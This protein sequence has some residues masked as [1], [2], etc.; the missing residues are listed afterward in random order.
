M[1]HLSR[2]LAALALLLTLTACGTAPQPGSTGP[3]AAELSLPFDAYRLSHA[4]ESRIEQ[5]R[6]LLVERCMRS[7]D[8]DLTLPAGISASGPLSLSPNARRYGVIDDDTA[9]RYGYHFPK[10][11]DEAAEVRK[12][13]TWESK[14]TDRH[15]TALYGEDGKPGCTDQAVTDI[16]KGVPESDGDFLSTRDFASL[17]ESAKN[18]DVVRAKAAWRECMTSAGFPYADPDAA[19]SDPRWKLDS[20][21]V[22]G[23]EVDTARADVH[24]KESSRLVAVWRDVEVS[25]QRQVIEREAAQFQQLETD[26]RTRLANADRI[27]GS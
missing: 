13:Q 27:L 10:S 7:L 15:R 16:A 8:L 19:I 17:A 9:K 23:A 11:T 3:G 14:L 22:P 6:N 4:D 26:K 21:T 18:T 1:A 2:S 20:P 5:A 12:V 24:C 25:L